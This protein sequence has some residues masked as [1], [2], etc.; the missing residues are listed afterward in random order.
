MEVSIH[1][2]GKENLTIEFILS[3][4]TGFDTLAH[5]I[6]FGGLNAR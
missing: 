2:N 5:H 6:V 3:E 1:R 4:L